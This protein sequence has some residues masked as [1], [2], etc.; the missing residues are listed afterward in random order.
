MF[1]AYEFNSIMPISMAVFWGLVIY[2]LYSS[3]DKKASIE[4]PA[5]IATRRFADGD[6]CAEELDG[7]KTKG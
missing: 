4:S 2:L 6:T 3:I 5:D 7:I 1:S